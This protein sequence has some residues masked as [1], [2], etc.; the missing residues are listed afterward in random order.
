MSL[1]K[2]SVRLAAWKVKLN[3]ICWYRQNSNNLQKNLIFFFSFPKPV[4]VFS[5]TCL[6]AKTIPFFLTKKSPCVTFSTW[7]LRLKWRPKKYSRI[8]ILQ[9]ICKKSY[10]ITTKYKSY[11]PRFHYRDFSYP[12]STLEINKVYLRMYRECWNRDAGFFEYS[13]EKAIMFPLTPP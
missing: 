2:I 7:N 4:L 6:T 13:K 9:R 1:L 11:H 5:S 3:H 12:R 8:N 10:C